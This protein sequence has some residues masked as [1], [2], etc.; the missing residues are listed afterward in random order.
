MTHTFHAEFLERTFEDNDA[1]ILVA[2]IPVV[3]GTADVST[4][5]FEDAL[6]DYLTR[7]GEHLRKLNHREFIVAL[8]KASRVMESRAEKD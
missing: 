1:T 5:D 7:Y 6:K 2:L 3:A 8:H 4:A